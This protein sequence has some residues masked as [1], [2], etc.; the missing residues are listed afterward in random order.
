[1]TDSKDRGCQRLKGA[2]AMNRGVSLIQ[3]M[4]WRLSRDR[5]L[6]DRSDSEVD[7]HFLLSGY[8]GV[9]IYMELSTAIK[10]R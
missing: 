5:V 4:M 3:R 8:T 1:M 9:Y 10:P 7:A 2:L 6:V